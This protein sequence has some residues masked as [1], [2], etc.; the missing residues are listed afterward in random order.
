MSESDS[1]GE[2][3]STG[4]KAKKK[5][6]AQS[7]KTDW[8]QLIEFKDWLT[9]SEKGRQFAQ[10]K[11]C[12]KVINIS[13]EKD[14]LVKYKNSKCHEENLK[15]ISTQVLITKFTTTSARK[16]KDDIK[17]GKYTTDFHNI[18]IHILYILYIQVLYLID[19]CCR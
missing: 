12:N 4:I 11:C 7:Y 19:L 5:K 9:S 13:S 14:S 15:V 17:E 1:C 8:E 3:S 6:Y 2:G 18:I 16:L 10:C